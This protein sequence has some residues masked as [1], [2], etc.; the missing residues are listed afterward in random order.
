M[1]S[2]KTTMAVSILV[3][4]LDD[5][6]LVKEDGNVPGEGV[7]CRDLLGRAL[8]RFR[9]ATHHT[10]LEKWNVSTSALGPA[11]RDVDAQLCF[12]RALNWHFRS[13]PSSLPSAGV[14]QGGRLGRHLGLGHVIPSLF[15]L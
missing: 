6:A 14:A 12:C 11:P 2:N 15:L 3:S 1:F 8:N 5:A 7:T 4:T 10:G 13:T 9:A